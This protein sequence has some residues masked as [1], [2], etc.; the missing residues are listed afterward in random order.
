MHELAIAR[1][2]VD[3]AE[4]HAGGLPVEVVRVKVGRLRQVVPEYLGFNF[5]IAAAGTVCEGAELECEKTPSLLRCRDCG[6]E[7]DPAPPPARGDQELIVGFRCPGC[8]SADHE[9]A[10][11]DEL[12]VESIDVEDS[13]AVADRVTV[14]AAENG[15]G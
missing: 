13:G 15:G 8:L 9:V 10:S 5:E 14:P 7:W 11:G 1:S 6:F 2:I 4:R 3:V 12:L